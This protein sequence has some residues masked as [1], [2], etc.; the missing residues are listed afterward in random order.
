[1]AGDGKAPARGRRK[2]GDKSGE[3]GDGAGGAVVEGTV[4]QGGTGAALPP[5]DPAGGEPQERTDEGTG[6]AP[7][8][9]R[10]ERMGEEA[11]LNTPSLVAD[12]RDAMLD[13]VKMRPKP[14]GLTPF[15][16]QRDVAAAL[17]N[18]ARELVRKVVEA[19]RAEG[20]DPIRALLESYSE[21]DGL[22]AQLKIKTFN[23]E[24]ALAAVIGLH[25]AVGKH[26]LITVA[27]VSDFDGDQRDPELQ[28]DQ[29]D[30]LNFEAG[31]DGGHP[32][33]D[34]DLANEDRRV[35]PAT[36]FIERRQPPGDEWAKA[37]PATLDEIRE[38]GDGLFR[39]NL[40]SGM[41]ENL[42]EGADSDD[43]KAWV[44]VRAAIPEELA[45]ERE[46]MADFDPD[47]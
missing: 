27:S 25:M 6:T 24:E 2:A 39:L 16:E 31:G 45:A 17:E 46:S 10:M 22:K 29:H 33:D 28:P 38:A 20:P 30:L 41:I 12:L 14:W 21:K 34:S 47:Q 42:P 9:E 32:G 18:V 11:V 15:D 8:I 7:V 5:A 23:D 3:S 35:N 1:M 4:E 36:G 13:Q 40:K 19:V 43:E 37:E 44:D 26:V